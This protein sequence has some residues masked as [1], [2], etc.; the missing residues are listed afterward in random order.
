MV[1]AEALGHVA[2]LELDRG[3]FANDIAAETLP[4]SGIGADQAAEHSNE[5][6]IAAAVLSQKS[7]NLAPADALVDAVDNRC[8]RK[9]LCEHPHIDENSLLAKEDGEGLPGGVDLTGA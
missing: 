3:A 9:M 6:G 1:N 2:D 7:V 8:V 5:V 4:A